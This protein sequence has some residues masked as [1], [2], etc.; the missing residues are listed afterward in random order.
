MNLCKSLLVLQSPILV[1]I[2]SFIW[3]WSRLSNPFQWERYRGGVGGRGWNILG[4][5]THGLDT[6]WGSVER[7]QEIP[8]GWGTGW[9]KKKNRWLPTQWKGAGGRG[10]D[11]KKFSNTWGSVESC[12]GGFIVERHKNRT[13]TCKYLVN[14]SHYLVLNFVG[15]L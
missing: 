4:I 14:W 2:L 3:W 11:W 7:Y 5:S 13:H 8:T 1:E 10:L 6:A 12:Q 15:A 9:E